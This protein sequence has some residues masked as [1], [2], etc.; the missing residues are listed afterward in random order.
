VVNAKVLDETYLEFKTGK[1]HFQSEYDH[2]R[3]KFDPLKQARALIDEE[4][5]DP[6]IE[7]MNRA[8]TIELSNTCGY[9]SDMVLLRPEFIGIDILI[10]TWKFNGPMKEA[11]EKVYEE[12]NDL[13]LSLRGFTNSTGTCNGFNIVKI[14]TWDFIEPN[15]KYKQDMY[16]TLGQEKADNLIRYLN[17]EPLIEQDNHAA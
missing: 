15:Q 6:M 3:Y 5:P 16:E 8:M 17:G 11:A 1:R 4:A 9:I 14:I 13:K 2:P 12:A 10:G 7:A